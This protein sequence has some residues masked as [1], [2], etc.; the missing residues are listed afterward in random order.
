[1]NDGDG[2]DDGRFR[3][4][5]KISF[6]RRECAVRAASGD[7]ARTHAPSAIVSGALRVRV[8]ASLTEGEGHGEVSCLRAQSLVA[9]R[10]FCHCSRRSRNL[11]LDWPD[12]ISPRQAV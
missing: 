7:G 2:D 12:W 8:G 3:E 4:R 6:G 1:M 9:L 5:R 10:A 11:I